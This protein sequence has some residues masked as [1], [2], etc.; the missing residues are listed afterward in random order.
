MK[1]ATVAVT[2]MTLAL[3]GWSVGA[4]GEPQ[5]NAQLVR[6]G[7]QAYDR[8]DCQNCHRIGRVGARKGPLDGVASKMTEAEIRQWLTD[9]ASMEAQMDE[10]PEGTNSMAN[11]LAK[12]PL[13][14]EEINGLTAYM[15]T[16]D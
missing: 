6:A 3:G 7:Q 12:K 2:L 5:S 14:E 15:M 13:T 11:T 4:A 8:H 10:P 9:P 16:L 1:F